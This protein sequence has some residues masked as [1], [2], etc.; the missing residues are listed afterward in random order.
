MTKRTSV[1]EVSRYAARNTAHILSHILLTKDQGYMDA[2][3]RLSEII[4]EFREDQ[5]G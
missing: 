3:R 4:E 1:P 5:R 2:V